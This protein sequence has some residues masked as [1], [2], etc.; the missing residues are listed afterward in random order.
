MKTASYKTTDPWSMISMS[1]PLII[2]IRNCHAI[3]LAQ[4]FTK[5]WRKTHQVDIF[6]TSL[7][8]SEILVN[9]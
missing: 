4:D 5:C 9:H 3:N 2:K 8:F 1:V 7:L 6:T